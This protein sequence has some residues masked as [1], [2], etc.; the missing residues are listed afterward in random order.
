MRQ[1]PTDMTISALVCEIA[2]FMKRYSDQ[3]PREEWERHHAVCDELD[4]RFAAL[5]KA[6]A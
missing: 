6:G 5:G 4:R 3:L 1:D 2:S